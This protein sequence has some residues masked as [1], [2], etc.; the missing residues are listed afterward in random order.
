MY[1]LASFGMIL[2]SIELTYHHSKHFPSFSSSNKQNF[3]NFFDI[4]HL[5]SF[6]MISESIKLTGRQLSSFPDSSAKTAET[7]PTSAG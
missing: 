3:V 6:G 1:H 2:G 5:A 4:Y 7:F